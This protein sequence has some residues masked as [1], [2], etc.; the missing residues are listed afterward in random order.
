MP[1]YWLWISLALIIFAIF[2]VIRFVPNDKAA[3]VEKL[4]ATQGS[5]TGGNIIALNNEAGYQADLVRGGIHFGYWRWQYTF[6]SS[7]LITIRQGKIGYVFARIGETLPPSQTLARVVNCDNYQDVRAFLTSGGQKGRQRGILREG[8]YAINPAAFNVITEDNIYA[9]TVDNVLKE[10]HLSLKKMGGFNPII[11]GSSSGEDNIGIVTTHDGPSLKQGE[12]IARAVAMD[13]S[14][15]NYHNNYQDI[16]AFLNAGGQ[17]GLQ[18]A[19][20]LDGTYFINIWFATIER[21]PKVVIPIGYV[22]VVVS[23]HGKAGADTSGASFRHGERVHEGERGVWEVT[24]GPGKY[25]FNKYAGN[26]VLVPTTNF[27]LHWVTGRSESHNF[28]ESL[29]SIDLIT[30]DAYEPLLPLSVVVHIDYQKAPNVIQRFGD[31]KQLITQTLDPLLSAYFRDIAHK[32]TML[33]LVHDRDTIQNQAR[34]ELRT[35]FLQFDIECVDVLIGRPGSNGDDT[36]IETLLEQL[37]LRQLSLE[38]IETYAK[39]EMAADKEKNL[40]ESLARARMQTDLTASRVRVD[41]A[42]NEGEADFARATK[43]AGKVKVMAEADAAR[44]TMLAEADAGRI[45]KVGSSEASVLEKKVESFGDSRLYALSVLAEFITNS[46]QPIVPASLITGGSNHAGGLLDTLLSLL[47]Q[48]KAGAMATD[49][50][51]RE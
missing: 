48:E 29:M 25:S 3:V 37:R 36:K 16:E 15:E 34:E 7:Q 2:L 8:V 43:E 9:L 49:E 20:L 40:N 23:Y 19:P 6:H 26:I 11:I 10:Y 18:Y 30:K 1:T 38:Q 22:G 4:W 41:I 50:P 17:R 13:A 35:K 14:D 42:G 21:I 47:V 28:D 45:M 44:I 32:K 12:I 31:V 51:K 27:V 5:L 39:Q 46:K 33:E 24:L